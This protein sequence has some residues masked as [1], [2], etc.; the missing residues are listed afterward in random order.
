MVRNEKMYPQGAGEVRAAAIRRTFAKEKGGNSGWG[1]CR[2][3]EICH[4]K[5]LNLVSCGGENSTMPFA[6]R[7]TITTIITLTVIAIT[8]KTN[9]NAPAQ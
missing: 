3:A 7:G 9:S 8:A 5:L 6:E 2:V 1:E 4:K